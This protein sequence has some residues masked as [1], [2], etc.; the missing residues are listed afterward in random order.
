MSTIALPLPAARTRSTLSSL[1]RIEAKRFARHPLFLVGFVLGLWAVITVG[2]NPSGMSGPTSLDFQVIPAFFVGVLGFVVAARL[3]RST[4]RSREVIDGAPASDTVRTAA[5]CIACLV[6]M[7]AG[8]VLVLVHSAFVSADPV[9]AWIYGTYG[10]FARALITGVIPVIAC[11]GGPLLG[12]TVGRW[13]RFPGAVLLGV[14]VLL[15]WA[16]LAAY[17]TTGES[18]L[19]GERSLPRILHML[20]PYTAFASANGDGEVPSTEITSFTGSA[21]W[22]ALWL[23]MLCGL[24]VT[25]ALWRGADGRTRHVVGRT[26]IGLSAAAIV[27]VGLAGTGG[28][29]QPMYT[30]PDGVTSTA[31]HADVP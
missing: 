30:T 15:A 17:G 7:T 31:S 29:A 22:Y 25:A 19:L 12:V 1:A 13:L 27:F 3:T 24:A 4:S 2:S 18:S 28:N 20:A 23:L 9:P 8:I 6:P 26:F 5:L 10:P 16:N 21:G 14:V 11:L